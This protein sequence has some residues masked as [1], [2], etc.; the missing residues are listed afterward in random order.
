MQQVNIIANLLSMKKALWDIHFY[1]EKVMRAMENLPAGIQADFIDLL[2]QV[3]IYGPALGEPHTKSMGKGLY[4][5]RAHGSEGQGRGL[6]CSIK[7]NKVVILH[8]FQKKS[9]KTPKK[10]LEL[11]YQRLKEVKSGK[12]K[13]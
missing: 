7:E 6:F 3:G 13:L 10:D 11:G 8:V 4:E 9:Q 1:S 5:I 12:V 2:D